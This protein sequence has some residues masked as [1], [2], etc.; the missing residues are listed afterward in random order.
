[1]NAPVRL[2]HPPAADAGLTLRPARPADE[3]LLLGWLRDASPMAR[4]DGAPDS[5][6][7]LA[8]ALAC[9]PGRLL[10]ALWQGRPCGMVT[11]L[12]DPVVPGE[13]ELGLLLVP[14]VRGRGLGS[15]LLL[16]A[17]RAAHRLGVAALRAR[18]APENEASWRLFE[19]AG[20]V[21][22]VEPGEPRRCYRLTALGPE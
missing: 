17:R 22:E 16:G 15:E 11:L 20:A 4:L 14:G 1:M 8:I 3:P 6:T 13:A 10:V 7:G 19:R 5:S 18:V 12:P 9:W 2:P 21:V